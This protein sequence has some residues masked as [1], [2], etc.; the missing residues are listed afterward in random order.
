[1]YKVKKVLSLLMAAIMLIGMM[2]TNSLAEEFNSP[3]VGGISQLS[4]DGKNTVAVGSTITLTSENGSSWDDWH[5]WGSSNSEVA[6]VKGSGKTATVTGLK[7]GQVR[8]THSYYQMIS[9]WSSEIYDVQITK[10]NTGVQDVYV[11]VQVS[12]EIPGMKN[13]WGGLANSRQNIIESPN[14]KR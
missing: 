10:E 11:F 5:Q 13:D 9:G 1:M 7:T 4:I 3:F 14:I 2:P 8:I 12:G 6:S